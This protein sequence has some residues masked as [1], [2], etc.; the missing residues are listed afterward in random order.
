MQSAPPTDAALVALRSVG[1]SL[2]GRDWTPSVELAQ[3]LVQAAEMA[4]CQSET[5]AQI[6]EI[7]KGLSL[8]E[9][10]FKLRSARLV[11]SNLLVAQRLRTEHELGRTL[12]QVLANGRPSKASDDPR[13]S[14]LG[15][16]YDQSATFQ[17]L[18]RIDLDDLE[19]RMAE[20]LNQR[21]LS[22]AWAL[23]LISDTVGSAHVA[24][25]SG[26]N[27]W[28]TP[29][30]YTDAARSTMG[31]IDFDPASSSKAN[32]TVRAAVYCDAECDGLSQPWDG[33]VW[34]NPPY[35]Q[36]LISLFADAAG[37]K[38]DAGE[39]TQACILVNNAS[40]TTWF[41]RLLSSAS[42]LCFVR[43]RIKFI[44]PEGKASGAPLQGQI[45]LYLGKERERFR[46][47]FAAFGPI[48]VAP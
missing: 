2:Q 45:V 38:Y 14:D 43:G 37:E 46:E 25:N 30:E 5:P 36:P 1:A 29:P 35:A 3:S 39:I 31:S 27:E 23:R 44:D 20:E 17:K 6:V 7:R 12:P 48:W 4:L 24:Y 13:L 21:E 9:H 26:E 15:L 18:A 40:E 11:E 28:Y 16:S 19:E 47:H 10:L 22:T 8:A 33:N 34:M 42:A 41:Q 32:E